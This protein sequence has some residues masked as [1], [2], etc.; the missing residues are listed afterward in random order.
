MKKLITIILT[1]ALV[2]CISVTAFADSTLTL[3][4]AFAETVVTATKIGTVTVT[5]S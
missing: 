4:N 2:L 5:I 3:D 1:L